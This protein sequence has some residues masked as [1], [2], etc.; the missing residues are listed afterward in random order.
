MSDSQTATME[1]PLRLD[2]Q[3]VQPEGPDQA[4]GFAGDAVATLE[5]ECAELSEQCRATRMEIV[6]RMRLAQDRRQEAENLRKRLNRLKADEAALRE[7]LDFLESERD[8]QRAAHDE[9]ATRLRANLTAIEKNSRNVEFMKG[10]IS[11][12][13]Q[14][15]LSIRDKLPDRCTDVTYLEG[16]ITQIEED[17]TS[18]FDR[19]KTVGK[20]IDLSYYRKKQSL[21]RTHAP[22]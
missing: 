15:V 5:L 14:H 19:L 10:E 17:F 6:R 2:V 22:Y 1:M 4:S 12:L 13:R 3:A 16:K 11:A 20:D 9:W 21:R 18:F 8:S 7:E